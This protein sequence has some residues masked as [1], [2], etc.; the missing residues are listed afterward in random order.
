MIEVEATHITTRREPRA[1]VAEVFPGVFVVDGGG[2]HS[3][4][5]A[6]HLFKPLPASDEPRTFPISDSVVLLAE[7][8][9]AQLRELEQYEAD[10][11]R[12]RARNV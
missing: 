10:T 8:Q 6:G 7:T 9:D 4:R 11:A 3:V 1:L 2:V 12:R 5:E